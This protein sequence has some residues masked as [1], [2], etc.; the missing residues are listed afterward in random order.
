[1]I[2]VIMGGTNSGKNYFSKKCEKYGFSR[3]ITNT[4]RPRR[5]D[6]AENAYHFLTEE[7]FKEKL[8][9]GLMLEYTVYNG[10]YYGVS[11]DSLSKNCVVILDPF[12]YYVLKEKMGNSV[13]GIYLDIPEEIRFNRGLARGDDVSIL[14]KRLEEDKKLFNDTFKKSVSFIVSEKMEQDADELLKSNMSLFFTK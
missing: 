12:G 14:V 9:R 3:V 6:D 7:E 2:L 4:T 11:I 8:N 5:I 1:M 13:Y 10:N